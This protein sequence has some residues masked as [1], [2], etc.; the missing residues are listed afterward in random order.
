MQRQ[1]IKPLESIKGNLFRKPNV[2]FS[3]FAWLD[4]FIEYLY[5]ILFWTPKKFFI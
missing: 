3:F 1:N 4:W 2:L 5:S